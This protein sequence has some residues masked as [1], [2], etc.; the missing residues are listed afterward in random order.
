CRRGVPCRRCR[1]RCQ[2]KA[3][4]FPARRRQIH[5]RR[6]TRS[7]ISRHIRRVLRRACPQTCFLRP[8]GPCRQQHHQHSQQSLSHSH[9]PLPLRPVFPKV[10]NPN[11]SEE[12]LFQKE[13]PRRIATQAGSP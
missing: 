4:C 11:P 12:I 10:S 1:R 3:P 7:E 8:N 13:T 5:L 9:S 6:R 2:R